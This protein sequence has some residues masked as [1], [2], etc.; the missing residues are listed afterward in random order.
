[1][2]YNDRL[3]IIR[4]EYVEG[5]FEEP[6]YIGK[7]ET[8]LPAH[9]APLTDKQQLGYFGT[10]NKKAFKLHLQG[11]QRDI[12]RIRYNNVEYDVSDVRYHN[13]A[14]VLVIG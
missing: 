11:V 6:I 12:K 9:K 14:T 5:E 7:K 4:D 13:N 3:V 8:V 10:Y 2:I 1:M